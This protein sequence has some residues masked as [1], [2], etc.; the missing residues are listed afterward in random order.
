MKL[1]ISDVFEDAAGL[2]RH[3]RDVLLAVAGVFVFLPLFALEL[4][5]PMPDLSKEGL[6]AIE[7]VTIIGDWT[8]LHWPVIAANVIVQT[9]GVA[10]LLV[11]LLDP[12]RPSAAAA[13]RRAVGLVPLLI[14]AWIAGGLLTMLGLLLIVPG[15]YLMGRTFVTGPALIAGKTANPF[16]AVANGIAATRNNGWR[17]LA[18][19]IAVGFAASFIGGIFNGR[20]I[21]GGSPVIGTLL[22][23]ASAAVATAGSLATVLLQAAAY[24]AL[25]GARQGI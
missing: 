12:A 9:F 1:R 19:S 17:L 11:L 16:E 13:M 6:T 24:R 18:M 21:V 10:A 20:D 14:L 7:L 8:T 25:T 4:F 23:A 3:N 15:F 22:G 2:F 5:L